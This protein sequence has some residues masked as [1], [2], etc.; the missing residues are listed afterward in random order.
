M[1]N[2]IRLS[3]NYNFTI[4]H[5]QFYEYCLIPA[6]FSKKLVVTT[7]VPQLLNNQH[8]LFHKIAGYKKNLFTFFITFDYIFCFRIFVLIANE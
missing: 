8:Y 5:L 4:I 7:P 2:K 6:W 1:N 3:G